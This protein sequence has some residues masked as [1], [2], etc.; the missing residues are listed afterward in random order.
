MALHPR[1][2]FTDLYE[3]KIEGGRCGAAAERHWCERRARSVGALRGDRRDCDGLGVRLVD[4]ELAGPVRDKLQQRADGREL[5]EEEVALVV[6]VEPRVHLHRHKGRGRVLWVERC[7]GG[8]RVCGGGLR[9]APAAC[10]SSYPTTKSSLKELEDHIVMNH[11]CLYSAAH[12]ITSA[13]P[14]AHHRDL[15]PTMIRPVPAAETRGRRVEVQPWRRGSGRRASAA[16]ARVG[17]WP[18]RR[19]AGRAHACGGEGR[20]RG[21]RRGCSCQRRAA[22]GR[23]A[24]RERGSGPRG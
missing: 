10:T 20:V 12:P 15:M 24:Q 7:R 22:A 1:T 9:G 19:P 14:I 5:L 17:R 21:G 23:T 8:V 3:P 13:S 2:P 18:E 11:G 4:R 6:R 16:A